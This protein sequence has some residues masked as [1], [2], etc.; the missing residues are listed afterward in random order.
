MIFI[1]L[2][3]V[4]SFITATCYNRRSIIIVSTTNMSNA[5]LHKL[6]QGAGAR[7]PGNENL[8]NL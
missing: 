5:K 1:I 8:V 4:Y 6:Q 3:Q 2:I 7:V